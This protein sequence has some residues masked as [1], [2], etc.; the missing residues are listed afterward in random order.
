MLRIDLSRK[1]LRLAALVVRFRKWMTVERQWN[2]GAILCFSFYR[3]GMEVSEIF[4]EVMDGL[5]VVQLKPISGGCVRDN[6]FWSDRA[7]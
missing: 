1:P 4:V 6:D 7:R 3:S 2:M 5:D